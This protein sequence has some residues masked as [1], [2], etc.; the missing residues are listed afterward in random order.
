MASKGTQKGNRGQNKARVVIKNWAKKK[1]KSSSQSGM[2]GY[3]HDP[4]KGDI[5]CDTEG[6]YFPF[7]VEVKNYREINFCQL[8]QPNLK[9]VLIL[10]FWKQCAGDAK[11][12][13]KVPMLM[14]RFNGLP[15]NFFFVVITQEFA[16]LI[17]LDLALANEE[18]LVS[19]RYQD[20]GTSTALMIMRSD[21]VFRSD[22]KDIKKIAK[23]H[24]KI[25][26]K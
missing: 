20:Y 1:F 13:K 25:L 9:N 18:S 15:K 5:L 11:I 19:L 3:N 6:H 8:L 16:K 26:Y 22:Y 12:C 4:H 10:D 23:N 2:P 17:H 14:M 24:I 21:Q 7:T